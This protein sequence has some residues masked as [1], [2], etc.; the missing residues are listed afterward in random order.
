MTPVWD[1]DFP[2]PTLA[3]SDLDLIAISAIDS[4]G[5]PLEKNPNIEWPKLTTFG[6]SWHSDVLI[7]AYELGLFPMPYEIDGQ[8]SAIGWWSPAE[9]AIF[10]PDQVVV[11]RSL[12]K[13]MKKFSISVDVDFRAVITACANP[14]RDSG[15]INHDVIEA[16]C[17]L[18]AEGRA[19]SIEVRDASSQLVGGLYGLEIGGVF[20]GESMFHFETDASKAALVFLASTLDDGSGRLIDTQWMTGHLS[21]MGAKSISRAEYCANLPELMRLPPKF[22]ILGSGH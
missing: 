13:S 3:P 4:T 9:R 17:R 19:H 22:P 20:A 10:Y 15:W 5:V 8:D 14:T 18:H 11:S 16:F 12:R 21:A 1:N 6:S 7:S 2:D